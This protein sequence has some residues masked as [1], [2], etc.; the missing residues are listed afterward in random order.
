MSKRAS[1]K[2][3][4]EKVVGI[5]GTSKLNRLYKVGLLFCLI[6]SILVIV[7]GVLQV[8]RSPL[9]AS[10]Q[11]LS[12]WGGYINLSFG[13]IM[14]ISS[15]ALAA[16]SGR[17]GKTA[18]ASLVSV[19]SILS[20]ILLGGGFYVGFVLGLFGAMFSATHD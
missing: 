19:F 10:I 8:L 1:D 14:L 3:T 16:L 11:I 4:E 18:A 6:G 5:K 12:D 7:E 2:E 17:T 9:Q 13:I 15:L 20:L